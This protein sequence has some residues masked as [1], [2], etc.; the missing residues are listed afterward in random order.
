MHV[1]LGGH[2]DR[3]CIISDGCVGRKAG[4]DEPSGRIGH[5]VT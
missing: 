5:S 3:E 2:L 4:S 1:G